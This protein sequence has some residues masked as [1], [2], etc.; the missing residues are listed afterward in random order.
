M[1]LIP[2][3]L[4]Q[5]NKQSKSH[6]LTYH[7]ANIESTS[8]YPYEYM[9]DGSI[10][11]FVGH[12]E[13]VGTKLMYNTFLYGCRLIRILCVNFNHCSTVKMIDN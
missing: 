10:M 5:Y 1:E 8:H 4:Y 7:Y 3:R 9:P 6:H 13:I 12:H 11:M 2:G